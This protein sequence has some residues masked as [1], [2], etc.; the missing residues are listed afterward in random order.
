MINYQDYSE[1]SK[2]EVLDESGNVDVQ[3]EEDNLPIGLV[4]AY[5]VYVRENS[6][7]VYNPVTTVKKGSELMILDNSD[8]EW[9]KVMTA[10]GIEG[11]IMREFVD[12]K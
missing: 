7:K 10:S 9:Y 5:E 4:N 2:K 6:G 11:Y 1:Y 12:V 8:P 3:P